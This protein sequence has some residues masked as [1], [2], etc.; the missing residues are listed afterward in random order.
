MNKDTPIGKLFPSLPRHGAKFVR[1][2]NRASRN[3]RFSDLESLVNTIFSFEKEIRS[4]EC[5]KLLDSNPKQS[6]ASESQKTSSRS[7]LQTIH[8][9]GPSEKMV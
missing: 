7:Q 2:R 5:R 1:Q 9:R 3:S 8:M 4:N 6:Q